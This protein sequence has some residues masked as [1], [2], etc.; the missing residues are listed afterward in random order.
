MFGLGH[1]VAG[2]F[3]N[4]GIIKVYS[5]SNEL[6]VS[7]VF[8]NFDPSLWAAKIFCIYWCQY[9]PPVASTSNF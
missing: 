1:A 2:M 4:K 6:Y 5:P 8:L 9:N 3:L 7:N